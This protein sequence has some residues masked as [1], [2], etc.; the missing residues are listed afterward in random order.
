MAARYSVT[1]RAKLDDVATQPLRLLLEETNTFFSSA[2]SGITT[3]PAA[4]LATSPPFRADVI[5][6]D[7]AESTF[8]NDS[9]MNQLKAPPPRPPT[10]AV[11]VEDAGTK[12]K[13]TTSDN[14][15][16][17]ESSSSSSS[18]DDET[19]NESDSVGLKP[20]QQ[21]NYQK[22][23]KHY[24][25]SYERLKNYKTKYG[26]THVPSQGQWKN[27]YTWLQHIRHRKNGPYRTEPQL[28]PEEIAMFDELEIDWSLR[29]KRNGTLI[30][31]TWEVFYEELKTFKKEF[32]HTQVQPS[33][34]KWKTLYKWLHTNKRLK[35][36][37]F[38]N[39][40]Q[41]TKEQ[42]EKLDELGIDW[43]VDSEP[44]RVQF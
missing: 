10:A 8:A 42:I 23:S 2:T 34:R 13:T 1:R 40:R 18:V 15:N 32:G 29:R 21:K 31:N 11:A 6:N 27:L 12:R 19:V 41:L 44:D 33:M 28:T 39:R 16:E 43:T 9:D 7:T 37:P 24:Y 25:E 14:T 5:A 17:A 38:R 36:R 3:T 26:H 35:Y 22:R 20:T 4:A 30:T